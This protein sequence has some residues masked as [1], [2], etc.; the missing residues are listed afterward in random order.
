M[1]AIVIFIAIFIAIFV[2]PWWWT[3]SRGGIWCS[4]GFDMVFVARGSGGCWG[5]R[6]DVTVQLRWWAQ[7]QWCARLRGMIAWGAGIPVAVSFQC[8]VERA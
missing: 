1:C 8:R 6:H 2:R 5:T 3:Q 4:A 7:H